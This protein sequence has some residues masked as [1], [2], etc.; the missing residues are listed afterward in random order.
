M[1]DLER[2]HE[3][4]IIRE[5]FGY[6]AAPEA[7]A[8]GMFDLLSGILRRWYVV[9]LVSFSICAVGLPAIWFFNEPTYVVS[10]AIH[11][12]PILPN[13][14]TGEADNG[15]IS[16]YQMFMNT[17]ARII[18]SMPVIEKAADYLVDKKLAFFESRE[19]G[20]WAKARE[21]F[22]KTKTA[23][24]PVTVLKRAMS[25]GV[26]KVTP[27]SRSELIEVTMNTRNPQEA[28]EIVN[29]IMREY[30]L[31][32]ESKSDTGHSQKLGL[33]DEER[34]VLL[35]KIE[36]HHTKIRHLAQEYGTTTLTGRQ[37]MMLQRVTALLSEL[38]KLEAR[39][40]SLE[41][42]RQLL[43][44]APEQS[45]TPEDLLEMRNKH[46]NS[47]P[48]VQELTRTIVQLD[49][50]L[51]V[52]EQTLAPQNPALQQKRDLLNAFKSRLEDRR[53][54]ASQSFD[55]LVS[56]TTS[57]ANKEKLAAVVAELEQLEA[58]DKRLRDV[59]AKEDTQTI[60][61]G[62]K[63][64]D[65]QDRQF[66]LELDKEMYDTVSRR[67]RELE[68]ERKRPARISAAYRAEL[69][70][71]LD[72]RVKYSAALIFAA[73]ACG[74]GMAYLR[75]KAD[76]S[77]Y[78]PD[79]VVKRIGIRIIGTTTRPDAIKSEFLP[80]QVVEDYQTIRANLG[81]LSDNGMPKKVVVTSPGMKEGKT[82]FAVN[83]ATSLA[84]SGKKVLLIDGDLR[85]PDIAHM[86][87]LPK[88]SRG[89][90]DALFGAS[91][92]RAVYRVSPTNL[93]VL[94]ADSRN[95][96]DAYEL[97]SSPLM[98]K[99]INM[100]AK[101]YDHIIVDTPPVLAFPDALLWAKVTDAAIL[102]S[103]A[104]R[105]TAPDL[106]DAKDKLSQIGVRV[107]GMVLG[108]V[109]TSHGYY[110]YGYSYYY[111]QDGQRRKKRKQVNAKLLLPVHKEQAD[112]KNTQ[113]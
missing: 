54:E 45:I 75:N 22:D 23:P 28:K 37:D 74:M 42:Q 66:Q 29:A 77:V 106:K 6:E 51:I 73:L 113:S 111:S 90:Q 62:R 63:Q 25:S 34:K 104:G 4:E 80:R 103:F 81:L 65:I 55:D 101:T 97:L 107:L 8:P 110:R 30:E 35:Q 76:K 43:E 9:L 78:T 1:K 94:A 82:T 64:L 5:P 85:K 40:I 50:D 70:D 2:Y 7:A 16:N 100:A 59:L 15:E 98:A 60:E 102:T 18:T 91:L 67:I 58:Y 36:D 17:Q 49:Q 24:D 14:L 11:V 19:N 39:K 112:T 88:G 31:W 48:T 105:T 13:I 87:N 47:D 83:L 46:V 95:R 57:R 26:I 38:T 53:Q 72:N 33:L 84:K 69:A 41:T 27:G 86:L 71:V 20:F 79:D 68:M 93:D 92:D 61:L 12:A 56:Q 44:Q 96:N 52:A 89:L 32:E 99:Q 10:G 21:R 3:H 108:N 109:S